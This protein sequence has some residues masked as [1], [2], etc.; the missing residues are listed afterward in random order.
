MYIEWHPVPEESR[1]TAEDSPRNVVVTGERTK[2]VHTEPEC[3]RAVQ[4]ADQ[5][6]LRSSKSPARERR[7]EPAMPKAISGEREVAGEPVARVWSWGAAG[8]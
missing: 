8:L 5:E 7:M 6:Q 4:A 2:V 3:R 1:G